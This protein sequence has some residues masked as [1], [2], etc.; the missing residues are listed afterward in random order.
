MEDIKLLLKAALTSGQQR[1]Q[2]PRHLSPPGS[3]IERRPNTESRTSRESERKEGNGGQPSRQEYVETF[4]A[5]EGSIPT[6]GSS[7]SQTWPTKPTERIW[8]DITDTKGWTHDAADHS[9]PIPIWSHYFAISKDGT[10]SYGP[11]NQLLDIVLEGD[12]R[13]L[14]YYRHGREQNKVVQ[15]RCDAVVER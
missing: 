11:E 8:H 1:Q 12:L 10:T 2:T 4:P 6:T 9:A 7:D 13:M 5:M 15:V 14:R 3:P